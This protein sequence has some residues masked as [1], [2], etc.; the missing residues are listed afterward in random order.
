MLCDDCLFEMG[1]DD[2]DLYSPSRYGRYVC[3][4]CQEVVPSR[5]WNNLQDR[6][7]EFITM[8]EQRIIDEGKYFPIT[9]IKLRKHCKH[10]KKESENSIINRCYYQINWNREHNRM[11]KKKQYPDICNKV[12]CPILKERERK[13]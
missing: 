8:K 7:I 2:Y 13:R 6:L 3:S 12:E 10:C 1:V 5:V 9:F 4:K 11:R